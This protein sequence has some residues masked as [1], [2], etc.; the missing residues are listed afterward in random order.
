MRSGWE[1]TLLIFRSGR[2]RRRNVNNGEKTCRLQATDKIDADN[3][4]IETNKRKDN[5]RIIKGNNGRYREKTVEPYA[6][7]GMCLTRKHRKSERSTYIL[8]IV[9]TH[10]LHYDIFRVQFAFSLET[11]RTTEANSCTCLRSWVCDFTCARASYYSNYQVRSDIAEYHWN[12]LTGNLPVNM[13]R[14]SAQCIFY[15][16]QLCVCEKG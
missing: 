16:V 2:H 14:L 5:W 4:N 8:N 13:H 1:N 3:Q 9:Q 6:I 12:M 15:S 7:E 10:T 11:L